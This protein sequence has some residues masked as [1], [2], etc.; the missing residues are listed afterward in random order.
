M[1]KAINKVLQ[2]VHGQAGIQ[3]G[4][5]DDKPTPC[6]SAVM[7]LSGPDS[8]L[9]LDHSCEAAD[10]PFQVLVGPT[11]AW[12]HNGHCGS[13][14]PPAGVGR[15]GS[16]LGVPWTSGNGHCAGPDTYPMVQPASASMVQ[17]QLRLCS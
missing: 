4:S 17:M 16:Q 14:G 2:I 9:N 3:M 8:C 1:I 6:Y 5:Y 7:V 15:T 10:G 12:G 13:R 11:Q